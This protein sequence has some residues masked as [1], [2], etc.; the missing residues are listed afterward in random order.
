MKGLI[1][2]FLIFVL[3]RAGLHTPQLIGFRMTKEALGIR[4]IKIG[5]LSHEAGLQARLPMVGSQDC[6]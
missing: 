3:C 4:I 1:Y 6:R 5:L 2:N